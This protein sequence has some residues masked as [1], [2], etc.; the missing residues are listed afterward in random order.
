M[1]LEAKE[2]AHVS[3]L[4]ADGEMRAFHHWESKV[5]SGGKRKSTIKP[6]QGKD[7]MLLTELKDILNCTYEYY[8]DLKQDDP[9]KLSQNPEYWKG[10]FKGEQKDCPLKGINDPLI[11]D[12]VLLAI[13]HMMV[14]TAPGHNDIPV[15]FKAMLKEECTEALE[16]DPGENIYVALPAPDLPKEPLTEM[17]RALWRIIKAIWDLGYQP[18]TWSRV[19][20]MSMFKVGDPMDP[21]NYRGISLI[22]VAMKIVTVMLAMRLSSVCEMEKVFVKEQGGFRSEEEAIAQFIVMVEIIR[23]RHL[24]GKKTFIVSIDFM[25]AFDKVMHEALFEKLDAMGIRGQILDLKHI[26][27]FESLHTCGERHL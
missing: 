16:T 26:L 5:T 6:V 9:E 3:Q 24:D 2:V 18:D 23:R 21:K 27:H 4:Y 11:W 17:G 1:K 19:T 7:G 14:G 10:K 22:C 13:R 15:M 25:K 8:K 20:D 12:L